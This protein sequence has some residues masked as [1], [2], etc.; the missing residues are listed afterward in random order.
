MGGRMAIWMDVKATLMIAYSDQKLKENDHP[1]SHQP[2]SNMAS[3]LAYK[4]AQ[5]SRT[6]MACTSN[7]EEIFFDN[8]QNFHPN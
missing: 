3:S 4:A 2:R 6:L 8:D 7:L 1:Q 5:T